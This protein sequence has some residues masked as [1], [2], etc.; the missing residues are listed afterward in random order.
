[1][2]NACAVLC[3]HAVWPQALSTV[4]ADLGQL[5]GSLLELNL[6]D[7]AAAL[8]QGAIT[9]HTTACFAALKDRLLS[10]LER[11]RTRLQVGSMVPGCFFF[12]SRGRVA[13]LFCAASEQVRVEDCDAVGAG[14][15]TNPPAGRYC[16]ASIAR[17]WV[18]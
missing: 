15:G 11:A 17:A 12:L 16:G 14:E 4:S 5:S 3:C 1:M 7:S 8:V 10:A 9:F 18:L 6:K 13:G 2:F